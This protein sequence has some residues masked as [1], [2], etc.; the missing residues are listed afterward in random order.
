[1]AVRYTSDGCNERTSKEEY[2]SELLF[3]R[4]SA[5]LNNDPPLNCCAQVAS[6]MEVT[7]STNLRIRILVIFV[8]NVSLLDMGMQVTIEGNRKHKQLVALD[9]SVRLRDVS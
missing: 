7:E 5:Q 9:F 4:F 1:M 8:E 6:S 3:H 2:G